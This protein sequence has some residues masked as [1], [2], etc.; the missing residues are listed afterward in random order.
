MSQLHFAFPSLGGRDRVDEHRS[1]F[2][3]GFLGL[4]PRDK[5]VVTRRWP[6]RLVHDKSDEPS[7][8][9]FNRRIGWPTAV[10]LRWLEWRRS[11]DVGAAER[12]RWVEVAT[13]TPRD[14]VEDILVFQI[15]GLDFVI[16]GDDDGAGGGAGEA[17]ERGRAARR[18][19]SGDGDADGGEAAGAGG[20]GEGGKKQKNKGKNRKYK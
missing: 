11:G 14:L 17:G 12:L 9:D 18:D 19:G 6:G 20:A 1:I 13:T 2:R 4:T 16:G 8:R 3:T 10:P 15:L 5:N 7:E